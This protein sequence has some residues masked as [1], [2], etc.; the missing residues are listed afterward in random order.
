MKPALEMSAIETFKRHAELLSNVRM[1]DDNDRLGW[2]CLMQHYRAPTRLL[3]WTENLL[4][5]LFFAVSEGPK[6][7]G[8]LWAMLPWALNEGGGAGWGIPLPD[9]PWVKYLLEQPYSRATDS[10]LAF[11]FKL[12]APVESPLAIEPPLRFPRMAVQA[13]T[14]TLHPTPT[15]T[16]RTIVDVLPNRKHLVRYIIPAA[17]KPRILRGL[18]DL[19]VTR[20]QLFPE[21]EGLSDMIAVD[22]AEVGYSPPEPPE[23][24]G[25]VLD[26]PA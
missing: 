3:D 14:F 9:S 20:K 5:A 22:S 16:T 26:E 21:L 15:N 10:M 7:D 6:D 1:P 19:G 12:Y 11:K 2:L 17:A 24:S 23:C 25:E 13:S 18:R 4:V 8:E